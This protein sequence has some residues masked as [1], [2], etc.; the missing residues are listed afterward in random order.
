MSKKYNN[1]RIFQYS[2]GFFVLAVFMLHVHLKGE[3][4]AWGT[5]IREYPYAVSMIYLV[6]FVV[7][8]II[9]I[10]LFVKY[11]LSKMK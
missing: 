1:D 5:Q 8:L 10:I 3:S 11:L 7:S 9:S 6:L 2:I 4:G